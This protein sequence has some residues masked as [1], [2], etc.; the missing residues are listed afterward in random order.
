[1]KLDEDPL[2]VNMNTIELKRKKVL[3]QPC[4]A[5]LTKG[6]KAI[7]R[8]KR[9]LRMFRPKNQEIGQW[10]KNE[11]GKPQSCSNVTFNIL[12]AK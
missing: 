1:M 10:K 7:I 9:Q 8:E 6:K 12:M 11:R 3:I 5:E 2:Q 4:Q